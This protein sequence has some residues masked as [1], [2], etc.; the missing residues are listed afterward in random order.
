VQWLRLAATGKPLRIRFAS[1]SA[2]AVLRSNGAA[3]PGKK[4]CELTNAPLMSNE[5]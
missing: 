4:I 3:S 1:I 5:S 2:C